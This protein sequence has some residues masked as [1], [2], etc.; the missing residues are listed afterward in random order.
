[1]P[2]ADAYEFFCDGECVVA[3]CRWR[4]AVRSTVP[5]TSFWLRLSLIGKSPAG[6]ETL[7]CCAPMSH[8]G[9]RRHTPI[10]LS[11]IWLEALWLAF[12]GRGRLVNRPVLLLERAPIV[13]GPTHSI[14][15]RHLSIYER[16]KYPSL[17]FQEQL[18]S[19]S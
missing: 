14:Q 2:R 6:R 18:W 5:S 9:C 13:R 16:S 3:L 4:S 15:R 17:Q 12:S 8:V 1:M 10:A 19:V 11:W 7:L